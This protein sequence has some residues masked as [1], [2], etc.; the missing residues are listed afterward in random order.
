MIIAC[1][2]ALYDVFVADTPSGQNTSDIVLTGTVGGSP[3]NVAVGVARLGHRAGFFTKLS[4]DMFGQRMCEYFEKNNVDINL[5]I[6]SSLNTTLAV[7]K[8]RDDG[9]ADYAFYIDNTA[10]VSLTSEELPS[11]LGHDIAA[12]HFG[13]YSTVVDPTATALATLAA[14]E[15]DQR[16]VSYDPNLRPSIEPDVDR[17]RDAFAQ[18]AAHANV[19][20]ASDEDISTL[21]G[22]V[23]E[24]RFV[25]DAFAHGAEI[26]F[27]TRGSTGASGFLPDGTSHHA[28][29]PSVRVVDTVGAGDTFQAAILHWLVSNG[30]VSAGRIQGEVDL[31]G[32][33]RLASQAAAITCTRAGANLPYLS[34]L[35]GST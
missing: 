26:V 8:T 32:C 23:S 5:S 11:E 2:D 31:A 35:P 12:L 34:E 4:T 3:M 9:S 22:D 33:I 18:F 16:L 6:M 20:K 27:I 19:I 14:R 21:H 25:A 24:D 17:W 15:G 1:G 28:E 30:H 29:A 10:D 13:S 7:V